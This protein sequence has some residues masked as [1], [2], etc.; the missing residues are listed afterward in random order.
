MAGK[1]EGNTDEKLAEYLHQISLD[2]CDEEL[3]DVQSFGWYGLLLQLSGKGKL[4][5]YIIHEDEQGFFDYCTYNTQVQAK[6]DWANLE[7]DYEEFNKEEA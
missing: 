4:K 5:S 3:G 7:A 2:G 6:E 1:F